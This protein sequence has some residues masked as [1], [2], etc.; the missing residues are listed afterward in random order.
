MKKL[1]YN[2]KGLASLALPLLLS[3]FGVISFVVISQVAPF[4]SGIFGTL[5]NKPTTQAAQDELSE[6][7][8]NEILVKFK[9]EV[10]SK[11]KEGN[12]D[13]TGIASVDEKLKAHKVKSFS[14]IFKSSKNL[15]GDEEI[16]GWYKI[17]LDRSEGFIKGKFDVKS[18]KVTSDDPSV[19]ELQA[20]ISVLKGDPNIEEA[21]VNGKMEVSQASKNV[22]VSS[23]A[24]A[25]RVFVTSTV[26]NGNLGGLAGADAKCQERA[27]AAGLGGAWKA[28]ISDSNISASS[29]LNHSSGA[30]VRLGG[31]IIANNWTDLIDGT[32]QNG[33]YITEFGKFLPAMSVW[34]Y[35]KFDGSN[36]PFDYDFDVKACNNYTDSSAELKSWSGWNY[37]T[38]RGWTQWS[39][40]F[41]TCDGQL[42]LYCIEQLGSA[43]V[44]TPT[45]TPAPTPPPGSP[46]DPYYNSYGSWGQA[47]DDLYGIKKIQSQQAWDVTQ[48]EGV[49]VAVVDTGVDR[50]HEDLLNN[51]WVNPGEVAGNSLDDDGNGYID[52]VYGW[53]FAYSNNDIMDRHGHGSHVSGTIAAVVNNGLGVASVA[54][55]VKIMAVKGLDDSGSGYFD[56]L[57]NAILYAAQN[58]A[59]VANNSWGCRFS[60]PLVPIVEDAIRAADSLGT[61]NVFAAGNSS[62]DVINISP[63]NMTNPK[64]LV[65]SAVDPFD[66]PAYFTNFGNL[67]D[68]A[69]PGVDVLSTKSSQDTICA[70]TTIGTYYCRLSGTSMSSPHAAGV[71][72]L[73]KAVNPSIS[74]DQIRQIIVSSA[75][76]IQV[77]GKD[78][79][80][81]SGRINAARAVGTLPPE[82]TPTPTPTPTPSPTPIPTPSPDTTPPTVT[83]TNPLNNSL[84][85]GLV[86]IDAD[87]ADNV[88][89][90]RVEFLVDETMVGTDTSAPYGAL[91]DA[92]TEV[93][94]SIHNL[95]ARAFD[96]FGNTAS[97]SAV[98]V[99]IADTAP[100]TPPSNLRS[101]SVSHNSVSIAWD[102]SA[103]NK[104]VSGYSVI[105]DGITIAQTTQ[106][107]FTDT[108]VSPKSTYNYYIIAYDAAGNSSNPSNTITVNTPDIPDTTPPSVP[109]N[110]TAQAVSDTQINLSWNASTDNIGVTGYDVYRNNS[111]ITTVL[112]TSFGDTSLIPSTT[113]SY[114]VIAKDAANNSSSPSNTATATTQ[115]API[116][117]GSITGTISS[118]AGGVISGAKV[119]M[120]VS[121]AKRTTYTN[122]AGQ[123]GLT[124]IPPGIYPVTYFY[125]Q[126]I[127]QTQSVTVPSGGTVI[128]NVT[129]QRR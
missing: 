30:Y 16:F 100:P 37:N 47:Y 103:D 129:L 19:A 31:Q 97:S 46:N 78:T 29:R 4:E 81:G 7:S 115:P 127:T 67:I 27:N 63:Q 69:A 53:S 17:T 13:N 21:T 94:D 55:K 125:K 92:T 68:V 15:K 52:D 12:P 62:M 6:F 124:N 117:N 93:V 109:T 83:I 76:D 95:V 33:I 120:T 75:D 1:I 73:V 28:W 98:R 91:W 110:L 42:P 96:A 5:F 104:A 44:P 71:A 20:L 10:R 45:P 54:P 11:V 25:S 35:T 122:S 106:I 82:P 90:T 84:V 72:A 9:K 39:A 74:E 49:I 87:A 108:T 50:N 40:S 65:V 119:T 48:G 41:T 24:P 121:G 118:T 66:N 107:N 8:S 85:A 88:G 113:Y 2:Q 116:I 102:A 70:S 79:Y 18:G 22:G 128:R 23:T 89:V 38:D 114:H 57:A 80:T 60:C 77:P 34:T 99:T 32:I 26:Y 14:K 126:H 101:T 105:R 61:L 86:D 56:W 3:A 111:L 123:Y 51:S 43:P 36:G 58:G 112:S 59:K 64:P